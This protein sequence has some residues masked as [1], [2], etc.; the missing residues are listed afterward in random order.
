MDRYVTPESDQSAAE[1]F[2]N[3]F[4]DLLL[5]GATTETF[6]DFGQDLRQVAT[7][8]A[9][10]NVRMLVSGVDSADAIREACAGL[11]LS[12]VFVD[13]FLSSHDGVSE[14]CA[15]LSPDVEFMQ[16]ARLSRR[17]K[18]VAA[19]LLL[20]GKPVLCP[21]T[22]TRALV[23]DS[24]DLH[25]FLHRHGS[26]ACIML[27]DWRID[28][29][30][31]DR[32]WYFPSGNLLLLSLP[33]LDGRIALI[34]TAMQVMA[35]PARVMAYL[36]DPKR[37]LMVSENTNG[38]LGHYIWNVVSGW[39]RLFSLVPPASIDVITSYPFWQV[40]GGVTE[41]FPEDAAGAGC[42]VRPSSQ[43][44]LYSLM[45]DRNALSLVLLDD[46][47]TAAAARCIVDWS[48]RQC[49]D[50]FL[51]EAAALRR[52]ASPLIML[53]IRTE[54][55][56][57]V[58]Q[59]GGYAR[60][61][62]ELAVEH[63]RLG[64]IFDGINAGMDQVGSHGW[65]SLDDEKAIAASIIE[66]CPDVHFYNALGCLPHESIVLA[67]AIDAFL[68][69]I[70]AGLAKTRWVANKPG[71]GFSNA[72]FMVPGNFQ[73]CLY[74][75]FRENPVPMR[76]VDHS[77]VQDV[78]DAQHGEVWRANFTMPWKAPLRELKSLLET[79]LG[80]ERRHDITTTS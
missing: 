63:P 64:V 60:I 68:A 72:S 31:S 53:T 8:W 16:D 54:N 47:V 30:A 40:F 25:T 34:R 18:D 9:H 32:C 17:L 44:S 38:H 13:A 78:G 33:H 15:A 6:A 59:Q 77:E 19:A 56:A 14:R 80:P 26:R 41:L 29:C 10:S 22:G 74:D 55:R 21:F 35:N 62:Q 50:A 2:G 79:L 65:M 43:E 12:P 11:G 28:Q 5:N 20:G 58:D 69:P 1:L 71:V 49:S 73:G 61:V 36:D 23:R 46:Y 3:C 57:W 7:E 48:R 39:P 45:L 70:G 76:Y 75:R 67:T 27:P 42:V 66:V 24:L 4:R 51:T 37:L 52:L